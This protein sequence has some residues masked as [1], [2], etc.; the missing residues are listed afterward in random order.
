MAKARDLKFCTLIVIPRLILHMAK[1]SLRSSNGSA[2]A[3]WPVLNLGAPV[4]F[5]EWLK[6]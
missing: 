3:M 5:L 4:I 2:Y 1:L 6:L